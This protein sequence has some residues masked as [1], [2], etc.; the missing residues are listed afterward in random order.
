M[1]TMKGFNSKDKSSLQKLV[2]LAGFKVPTKEQL[3][4]NLKVS[5]KD[6]DPKKPK[7]KWGIK[8]D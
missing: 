6:S 8:N 1:N 2:A 3:K 7:K 5:A 4:I